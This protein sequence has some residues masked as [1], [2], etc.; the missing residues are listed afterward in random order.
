MPRL[1]TF[2]GFELG[3]G[4]IINPTAPEAAAQLLRGAL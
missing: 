4:I 2:A 1:E 3:T